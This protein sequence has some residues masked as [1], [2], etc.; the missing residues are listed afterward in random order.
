MQEQA[1]AE[2]KFPRRAGGG[3]QQK[4]M[5]EQQKA[6][7]GPSRRRRPR[8]GSRPRP[9]TPPGS[10]T[11]R[12]SYGHIPPTRENYRHHRQMPPPADPEAVATQNLKRSLDTV[13]VGVPGDL[14]GEIHD[15]AP[16]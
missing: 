7:Q 12:H 14:G 5:H 10:N 15:P 4:A 3:K 8:P 1:K 13:K 6:M 16:R 9:T 2:R 11:A